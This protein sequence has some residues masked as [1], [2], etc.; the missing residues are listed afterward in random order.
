MKLKDKVIVVTGS[1]RGIGR[2]IAEACAKEGARVVI[3]SRKESAVKQT[4]KMF[5][6]QGFEVSGITVDVS[7]PGDLEKLL[8]HAIETW[9]RVDVWINNAGLSGGLR[10][11]DEMSE[12]EI[13]SIVDVNLT[14]MLQA[15]RIVIPHFLQY[16]GGILINMSGAGG[17]CEAAPFMTTYAA[18]KAAVTSL[19]KSLAKEYKDHPISIHSVIPGMV[20]TDFYKDI[21]VSPKLEAQAQSTPYALKAF[22]VPLDVVGRFFVKIAAQEPGKVTGKTYRLLGGWRLMRGIGLMMYYRATGKIKATM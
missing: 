14:G 12:E 15:C 19:T 22:S 6:K 11:F 5:N 3:C 13:T 10:F 2:G 17:R 4:L 9:G 16:G 1:T 21:K 20:E 18:T 8:K 7:V